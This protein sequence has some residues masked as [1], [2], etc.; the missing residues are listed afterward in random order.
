VERAG[1]VEEGFVAGERLNERGELFENF[2]DLLRDF[3]V[4]CHPHGQEDGVWAFLRSGA[5]GHGGVNAEFAGFIGAGGDDAALVAR[6]TD[7][8]G[9]ALE[10]RLIVLLDCREEGI[11]VHMQYGFHLRDNSVFSEPW[12]PDG[13][14]LIVFSKGWNPG[15]W[16]TCAGVPRCGWGEKDVK[17]VEAGGGFR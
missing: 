6:R 2:H 10:L 16:H 7:D 3:V 9:F 13:D 15:R 5:R 11:H 17:K 12:K 1:D 8:D 4:A 14:A